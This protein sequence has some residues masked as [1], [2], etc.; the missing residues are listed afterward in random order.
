[1]AEG[2]LSEDASDL[3]QKARINS[4]KLSSDLHMLAK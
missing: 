4:L 3:S 2:S 1:M